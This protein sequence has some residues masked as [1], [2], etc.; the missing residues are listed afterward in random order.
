[1]A[2]KRVASAA[3]TRIEECFFLNHILFQTIEKIKR[4][5]LDELV[6]AY[7][8]GYAVTV[9]RDAIAANSPEDQKHTEEKIFPLIGQALSVEQ[10]LGQ[11]EA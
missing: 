8:K 4:A 11:L 3:S 5:N 1:L 6:N 9:I 10:F 7:G 2:A